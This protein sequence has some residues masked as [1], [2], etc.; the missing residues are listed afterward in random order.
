M[1]INEYLWQHFL[2]TQ[3]HDQSSH[4][5]LQSYHQKTFSYLWVY[6]TISTF[7]FRYLI[8][9]L[10]R[11]RT[12]HGI[13]L[14]KWDLKNRI[15]QY[16]WRYVADYQMTGSI[17]EWYRTYFCMDE[18]WGGIQYGKNCLLLTR[19]LFLVTASSNQHGRY[20]SFIFSLIA[21]SCYVPVND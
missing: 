13:Y 2:L 15:L 14:A 8:M 11:T 5:S 4:V 21:C 6:K 1:M 19:T 12:I 3:R 20:L 10:Q 18:N 7:T 17:C 9:Q 16:T